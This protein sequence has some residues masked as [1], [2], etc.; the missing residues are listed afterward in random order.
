ML[1]SNNNTN[2]R[3]QTASQRLNL[4]SFRRI[5]MRFA[6]LAA[7]RHSVLAFTRMTGQN[8]MTSCNTSR[9]SRYGA[10]L[11]RIVLIL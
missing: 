5:L 3:K 8:R 11:L 10:L 6:Q 9:L 2:A 1:A 4:Q 7:I